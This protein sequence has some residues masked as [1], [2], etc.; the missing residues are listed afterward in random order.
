M[1]ITQTKKATVR[2]LTDDDLRAEIARLLGSVGMD[3][4]ELIAKGE[5]FELDATERSVLADVEA[6]EWM[7][8]ARC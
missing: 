8:A 4:D 6:M 1:T 2:Q 3:R 7:L 5:A